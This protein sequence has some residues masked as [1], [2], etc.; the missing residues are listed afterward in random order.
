MA[1]E[2]NLRPGGTP[3]GYKLSREQAKKGG[4][5]SAESRRRKKNILECT[6]MILENGV[7]PPKAKAQLEKIGVDPEEISYNAAVAMSMINKALQGDVQAAKLI[8]EWDTA[9]Q[10]SRQAE[11]QPDPLSAAFD[12]L[13]GNVDGN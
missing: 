12:S 8:A 2:Q 6:K 13:G 3:G 4:K 11:E 10:A 1:N 7:L 5:N 9:G